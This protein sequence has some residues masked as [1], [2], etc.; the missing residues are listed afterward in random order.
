[1]KNTWLLNNGYDENMRLGY[2]DW[3]FN[4]RLGAKS[5]FGKRL[6]IPLFHYSVCN[7]GCLSLN[8]VNTMHRFGIILKTKILNFIKIKI[9]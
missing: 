7:T 5:I 1:M 2:E 9:F 6:P 8:L 4:I 3:D